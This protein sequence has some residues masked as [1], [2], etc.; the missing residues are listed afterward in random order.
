MGCDGDRDGQHA[1]LPCPHRPTVSS[2][3]NNNNNH[4]NHPIW[5]WVGLGW[6]SGMDWTDHRY[7][8][9]LRIYYTVHAVLLST[10]HH[11]LSIVPYNTLELLP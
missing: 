2:S 6:P 3:N 1:A 11:I 5:G 8:G 10:E 7:Q 4:H 9:C